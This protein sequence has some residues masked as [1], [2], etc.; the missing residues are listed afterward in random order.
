MNGTYGT[1]RIYNLTGQMVFI[2]KI[3]ITKGYHEFRISGL[4]GG[5]YIVHLFDRHLFLVQKNYL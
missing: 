2:E 4:S 5:I 1:L 3:Y